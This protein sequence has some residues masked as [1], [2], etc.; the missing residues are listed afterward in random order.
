MTGWF[1]AAALLLLYFC[2]R[3]LDANDQPITTLSVVLPS[4]RP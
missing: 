3:F 2:A 1:L 4:A